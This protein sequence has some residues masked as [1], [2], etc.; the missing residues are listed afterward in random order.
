MLLFFELV[1]CALLK[2]R[3]ESMTKRTLPV[4]LVTPFSPISA[5]FI[6]WHG[7]WDIYRCLRL[8]LQRIFKIFTDSPR[9]QTAISEWANAEQ[10]LIADEKAG[11]KIQATEGAGKR[12]TAVLGAERAPAK[13]SWW[14]IRSN[15]LRHHFYNC[16]E[17]KSKSENNFRTLAISK[18]SKIIFRP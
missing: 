4:R 13:L 3:N 2:K 17:H 11:R 6:S 16:Y 8:N 5:S 9:R 18:Y 15:K 12:A 1:S 7:T 14:Q 10:E